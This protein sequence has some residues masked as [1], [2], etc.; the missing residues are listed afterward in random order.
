MHRS[1]RGFALA[2]FL[3][4]GVAAPFV[5]AGSARAQTTEVAAPDAG[6]LGFYRYPALHGGTIV[7]AAEGDLWRVPIEGGIAQRLTTHP[8]EETDPVIA[9]DGETLAF[10]ARYEGSAE[11]Y[12]MPLDGGVPVRRTYEAEPSIATAWTPDGRLVYTTRH[13]STLPDPQLVILDLEDGTREIVPLAVATEATFDSS[14]TKFFFVR[15]PFHNNVTK[16]YTGGTARDIW[17]FEEGAEEAVELTGDYEGESHSPMWWQGRV[18]FVSDRDGTM[19]LWSM[20]EDGGDLRQHTRH[21]GWDVKNPSLS[22]GRIVYQLGADLWIYDIAGDSA[23]LIPIT[24]ASDFDQLREKWV[25]DPMRYLTSAHIHPRG[26]SVVLTARGRVF[27]APARQGRFVRASRREGVRYRDVVFM[28]DGETLLGLSDESG[29]L[30]FV[31]IPADGIGEETPLTDDGAILR[32]QGHPSPDGA[33]VAYDDNN[34]DL[35]VL[36]VATGKQRKISE[37]REGIGDMAWS[38]DSRWLAYTMRAGNSFLQIK[39][40]NVADG[41]TV[42]LTSDRVNSFSPAWD[43]DGEFLYFLSDRHLRSLV[44]SP[45]GPRQPEPYFDKSIGIYHVALRK[46]LRSPFK[47]ADEL[48]GAGEEEAAGRRGADRGA[49]EPTR[50]RIDVDGLARRVKRV[51]V[52]PGNYSSLYANDEALFWR[53]RDSGP[54]ADSHL[55]AVKIGNEKVEPKTVVKDIRTFELSLDGRKILVRKGNALYVIDAR[56]APVDKLSDARV[57]LSDWTFPIDVREDWRQIFVD[58]WRLERDYFYDPGMHG[59]DWRAVLNKYLPLVDRVTTRN[60]LSDLIGRAVGELSALHTSVRGGDLRRGQDDIP[61]ATLGARLFRDPRA[62]GY[63]IDYIYRSDPDYPD[64]MSPLADPD[65]NI[66]PGDVIEA[67]DGLPT[68]DAPDIGA[69]LRNKEG[70]QVRLRVR[71]G[72]RGDIPAGVSRDVIVVPTAR[73]SALRYSDWEYTRRLIVEEKGGGKIGYVHLR[74]MGPNDLTQWYRQFYPVFDRQGLIIDVRHNRGG[75][76]DSFILEKLLRRAWMYWKRRVGEPTWNMQYAFRGHM[77]VLVDQNTASDGEAFAEGFRRLGL[78][79]VIGTRTWGGEIWLS[80]VN[81][82]SDGGLARAPMM[83]VYGPEGEWLI[84]QRGV[85]PDIVVDN[86]PHATFNGADA[87]LDAAIRYLLEQIEKDPREVPAP[88]P[89]PNRSFEYPAPEGGR[90]KM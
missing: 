33:W 70:R 49:S 60:E 35:W 38:P 88:P 86:L 69:L 87:Q 64:E 2:F 50:V 73:E 3:A 41:A 9:P 13:Y 79:P 45:W 78:G 43:P 46:E 67:V 5:P 1:I 48:G 24:L 21:S 44:G 71:S 23:R 74:A 82:L 52:P 76:I 40:Y 90:G 63:R 61:V 8:A 19:N 34:N 42:P 58:A 7:F 26:E 84:E 75:N 32:F 20:D 6:A 14:G 29:E 18:Y 27:V 56:P 81:R 85:I 15:P 22:Q 25:K 65:L 12:T 31:K 66:Q 89:Y 68:L 39:L 30:E 80:S 4:L 55:T 17:K 77:V 83:G 36:E 57:D 51:P 11:V 54:D 62:G 16:R 59:V 28:P 53:A 10:T 37:N 47:P 72:G